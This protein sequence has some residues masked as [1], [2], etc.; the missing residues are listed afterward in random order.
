MMP[1]SHK[2]TEPIDDIIAD[3]TVEY[4]P[5]SPVDN[6][7][8]TDPIRPPAQKKGV[9]LG[10]IISLFLIIISISLIAGGVYYY[11]Q[12][13]GTIN[14]VSV[15]GGDGCENSFSLR[16]L[17]VANPFAKEKPKLAGAEEGRTNFLIIGRD[18]TASLTDTIIIVSYYHQEKSFV[19]LNIPRDTYVTASYPNDAGRTVKISE[20]INAVYPFAEQA[21]S[22]EGSG[23]EALS[24]FVANE[25]NIP[26]HYWAV[27]NF[28]GVEQVV[29]KLGGITVNVDKAFTDC[30]FP[31]KNYSGF[32]RPCPGFE[33]GEQRM[34]GTKS[35]IYARSRL[36]PADG[37]D[38]ARSRRQSLVIQGMASEI[39]QKDIFS[40]VNNIND[41]LKILGNNVRTNMSL[42]DMLAMYYVVEET[43]VQNNYYK[44]IWQEGNGILCPGPASRGSNVN[45]CGGALMGTG[46]TSAAAVKARNQIQNM[47]VSAK[48]EELYNT[49]ITFLGNQSNETNTIRNNFVNGGFGNIIYNNAYSQNIQPGASKSTLPKVTIYIRD[50]NLLKLFN[51]LPDKPKGTYEVKSALEADKI[52]TQRYQDAKIIV[53]VE[54]VP[55]SASSAAQTAR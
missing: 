12:V 7:T 36:A 44:I 51:E 46:S 6:V 28:E 13:M 48:S 43:D 45:Y 24:N 35:L 22:K 37:G 50:E 40:N 1:N 19:T 42:Q 25:F 5:N 21:S 4:S 10:R 27:T 16:C 9:R 15:N 34:D 18:S 39:K 38:Y 49:Q 2:E 26:I 17:N 20:K 33:V 31:T 54:N 52:L 14:Q 8:T 11:T 3:T 41:Y 53:W 32:I 47:L 55:A 23:A 29:D 30:N